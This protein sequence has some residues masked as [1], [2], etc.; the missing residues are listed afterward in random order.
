MMPYSKFESIEEVAGRFDIEVVDKG[1]IDMLDI[2][3]PD[4][5]FSEI[6]KRLNDSMSFI[7]EVTICEDIIK[8]ILTQISI[9][10]KSLYV[11]SHVA[12]N[13]DEGKGLVGEPDYLIATRTKHGGMGIPPLCV[14]EAKKENWEKGWAQTLAEMYAASTQGAKVCYGIVTTGDVWMFGKL[15]NSIFTKDPV[16]ISATRELQV[17][18]NVLNW[19]FDKANTCQ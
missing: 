3:I 10:Y 11:W 6:T 7:N 17:V 2:E 19:V 18:F 16:K 14:M 12:Y 15:E 1:I 13:V 9:R 8:P 5:P 4:Y